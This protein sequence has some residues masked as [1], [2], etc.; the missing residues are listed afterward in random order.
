MMESGRRSNKEITSNTGEGLSPSAATSLRVVEPMRVAMATPGSLQYAGEDDGVKVFTGPGDGDYASGSTEPNPQRWGHTSP[1][2]SRIELNDTQGSERITVVHHS[3]AGISIEPDGSIFLT[4]SSKRGS[5]IAS[6]FGDVFVSAGGDIA[7]NGGASISVDT[8]GDLN[9]NVGG[10]LNIKCASYNLLTNVEE[11]VVDGHASRNVTK[12]QSTIIGGINRHTVAGDSRE[13]VVGNKI[14]DIAKNLTSRVDGNEL[15][16]ISGTRK[17]QVKG[18]HELTSKAKTNVYSD[19][20]LSIHTQGVLNTRSSGNTNLESKAQLNCESTGATSIKSQGAMTLHGVA[21]WNG[22]SPSNSTLSG[23]NVT[24]AG[25]SGID[26]QT[27]GIGKFW[28]QTLDLSGTEAFIKATTLFSPVPTGVLPPESPSAD[29]ITVSVNVASP[30]EAPDP[31]EADTPDVNDVIDNLTSA[32]K[33]PEYPGN[34]VHESANAT[35]L[36]RISDDQMEQADDVY[37]DYSGQNQGN[38]NGSYPG[39]V[40][41]TLPESPVNRDP[42]IEVVDPNISTP[43]QHELSAKISKYYSLGQL[44]NGVATK[45]RPPTNKWEQVV[46]NGVKLASNVLDPIKDKFPDIIITSWYRPAKAGSTNHVTGR[47]VDIVVQSRSLAKH[48]EIARFA[49]DNLPVDQV[50]LEK[51]TSGRT[52]VH[53]RLS[54]GKGTPKVITCG[55]ARCKSKTPGIDVNFLMRRGVR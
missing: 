5:G 52:H 31:A 34:G 4:S 17:V 13:Q 35:N 44:I 12:D 22:G 27:T 53:L 21:S 48:A 42:N 14:V 45:Y 37:N 43:S 1:S 10:T 11:V 25:T 9:L 49:R 51:N 55:D 19:A 40:V 23:D 33:Y 26:I 39:N 50:F 15:R 46:S 2:G 16:Q 18:D 3:G 28:T 54:E 38:I 7:I 32:R 47:A 24:V 29:A 20:D 36:G 41:D 8:P 6:P 30:N